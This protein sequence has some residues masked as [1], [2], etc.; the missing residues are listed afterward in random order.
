M[1]A[2]MYE[3]P[4]ELSFREIEEPPFD[5]DSI[6]VKISYSF[7]CATDI[8]TYKQG[9]PLIKPPT[10]LGHE[11]S[12]VVEKVGSRVAGF[13]PGDAV[14][15]IPFLN[16]G[17]CES[18]ARGRPEG[19]EE[20]LYPSNGALAERISMSRSYARRGLAKVSAETL[21][22]AALSEPVSCVLNSA[23]AF[24]PRPGDEVLVVGAGFM[25]VLNAMVLRRLFGVESSITD[26]NEARLQ[27]PASLGVGVVAESEIRPGRYDAIVL[28]APVPDLVPRYAALV[29]PYGHLVLFGGY[30]KGAAAQF[31]PNLVHYRGLRIV[32]TSG[33]NPDDFR[34]AVKAISG[35]SLVLGAFTEHLYKF[36]DFGRAF[37]D[38]LAGRVLKAGFE[39]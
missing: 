20:R 3:A 21:K 7:V 28:T 35:R 18:C 33:F 2:V 10:V 37:E 16:C 30:A 15:G 4:R 38:A 9:H 1:K 24:S 31:D 19:C 32:G 6:L 39:L 27:L 11:Y 22:E 34:V 25:G 17:Q 14:A 5:E 12:G 23:R 26:V 36:D 29:A 8:K 13:A